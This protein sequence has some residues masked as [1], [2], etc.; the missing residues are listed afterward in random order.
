MSTIRTTLPIPTQPWQAAKSR[1]LNG[2]SPEDTRRFK[3]ATLENLF[4]D[5][6]AAQK[7]HALN[8]KSWLLQERLSSLVD[9]VD[10]YGKALDVFSNIY[11]LI[12]CPIWGGLRV[13]LHIAGQAGKF[14]EELVG[15]L[16]Q[17]GD[18]LP[19]FLIY[20]KL[21]GKHERLLHALSN[22]YLDILKFCVFTK[23]FFLHAKR[24]M[25]KSALRSAWKPF[26]KEF[27]EYM[28][29]FR[30][31]RKTVEKEITLAHMIES[32]RRGE[33]ERANR[34]LQVKNT[35][36]AKRHRILST[37]P[38]INYVNKHSQRVELRHSGTTAWL[39]ATPQYGSWFSSLASACFYCYG[40]PG[41]GKSILSASLV[42][43]LLRAGAMSK[44]SLVCY[45]YCDYTDM[46]SLEPMAMVASLLQQ[47][48]QI[49]PLDR[50][51]EKFLSLFDHGPCLP[52]AS[53]CMQCF[54]EVLK[55]F[56]T[57]Y[58]VIDGIDELAP[59]VQV[60]ALN[61]I[62]HLLRP[63]PVVTKIFVTSR[64]G[65]Y[66]IHRSLKNH[67]SLQITKELIDK[68]IS[69]FISEKIEDII[70]HKNPLLNKRGLKQ[71]II[72]ALVDGANGM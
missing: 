59:E 51:D 38:A 24:S 33:M 32:A 56:K 8:C 30:K 54:V 43:S 19:R 67:T 44:S 2:L 14:Q 10:E 28:A 37:L 5:A 3:D 64:I 15:M 45:Y 12:L 6:S 4:Y 46:A 13:I 69:L 27:E 68:D 23:D 9:A 11:G 20:Q 55:E 26:R 34:A 36:I 7:K 31:H 65:E 50:F 57:A 35:K 29:A 16:A 42:D 21:F 62:A 40:I 61:L 63:A 1:F 22:A 60:F 52:A 71:D 39:Q 25:S 49:L 48:V 58:I 17:I 66:T 70:A 53:E 72:D 41:S 47:V 18:V